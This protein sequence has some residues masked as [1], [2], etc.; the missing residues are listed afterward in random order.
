MGRVNKILMR[1]LVKGR[2]NVQIEVRYKTS[3]SKIFASYPTIVNL[4]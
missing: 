4:Y 1:R 2:T 3:D